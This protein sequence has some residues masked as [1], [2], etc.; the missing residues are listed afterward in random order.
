LNRLDFIQKLRLGEGRVDYGARVVYNETHH[1]CRKRRC[2]MKETKN[3]KRVIGAVLAVV[4]AVLMLLFALLPY[5]LR[6]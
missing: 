5:L 3:S 4:M 6:G 1:I 2:R